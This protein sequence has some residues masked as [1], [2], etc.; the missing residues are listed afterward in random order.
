MKNLPYSEGFVVTP[1]DTLDVQYDVANYEG[2][3]AIVLHNVSAGGTVRVMPAGQSSQPGLTLTGSS[4][5]ANITVG[6]VAYLATFTSSL[7]TTATNFVASHKRALEAKG[8]FV[9]STGAVLVFTGA[10]GNGVT[11]ANVSGNLS[12]TVLAD[13]PVTIYITQGGTSEIAVRRVYA[14]TPTP[15]ANLVGYYPAK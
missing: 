12:G 5:T 6:G 7:T 3:K 2:V 1:S 10:V 14:S 13:T 8:I 4:G 9:R 15:P 11:I